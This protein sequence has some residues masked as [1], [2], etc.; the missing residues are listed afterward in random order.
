MIRNYFK[1][2]WR[3]LAKNKVFS[4]INIFGLTI[5]LTCCML[6]SLYIYNEL[7]YDTYH[8]HVDRIYQLGVASTNDGKEEYSANTS[9]PTGKTLQLDFPEIENQAR[10]LQLFLDDK[11]LLQY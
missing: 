1:I 4:F 6:I 7:S 8:K 5:G 11:T 2:A 9:A 3:N 10:L